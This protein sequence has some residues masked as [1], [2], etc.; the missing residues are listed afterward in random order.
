MLRIEESER[1]CQFVERLQ[2]KSREAIDSQDNP[3]FGTEILSLDHHH[4]FGF[5]VRA[6]LAEVKT[7]YVLVVQHDQEFIAGFDLP[8]VLATMSDHPEAVKYVGLSSL[9]SHQNLLGG[10][11]CV[12]E[13]SEHAGQR[14]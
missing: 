7:D 10:G 9:S 4:G 2:E 3:F 13:G 8:A 1:Y 5:A 11:T 12:G 14:M 6:A